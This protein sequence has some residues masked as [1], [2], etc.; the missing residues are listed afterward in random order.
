MKIFGHRTN[1]PV[2]KITRV[3]SSEIQVFSFKN[4]TTSILY[5]CSFAIFK[6]DFSNTIWKTWFSWAFEIIDT[7]STVTIGIHNKGFVGSILSTQDQHSI[8]NWWIGRSKRCCCRHR[9]SDIGD[10]GRFN[11]TEIFTWTATGTVLLKNMSLKTYTLNWSRAGL[12][13]YLTRAIQEIFFKFVHT[14]AFTFII[15]TTIIDAA[16]PN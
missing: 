11:T 3:E 1:L 14:N 4:D 9:C 16:T 8:M 5:C 2:L 6:I 13:G 12:F 10:T 15:T 7:Q